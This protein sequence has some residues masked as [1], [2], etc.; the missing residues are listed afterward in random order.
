MGKDHPDH[1]PLGWLELRPREKSIEL[2]IKNRRIIRIKH[3]GDRRMAYSRV[4]KLHDD[5]VKRRVRQI[6]SWISDFS[7][8]IS[9]VK[10]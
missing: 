4:L 5:F 1:A 8:K 7:S 3:P 2:F 10:K 6:R 9:A